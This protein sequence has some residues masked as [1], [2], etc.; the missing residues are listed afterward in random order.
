MRGFL[1]VCAPRPA[2]VRL[3]AGVCATSCPNTDDP[4]PAG[5]RVG[6]V[7]VAWTSGSQQRPNL[8]G[9]WPKH[10]GSVNSEARCVGSTVL[11]SS[12]RDGGG[13]EGGIQLG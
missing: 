1:G 3:A 5:G 12:V 9:T 13:S 10:L 11:S 7:S 4:R 6:R 2:W 8:A